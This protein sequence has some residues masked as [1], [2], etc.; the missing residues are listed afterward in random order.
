VSLR[1]GQI[2]APVADAPI[3]KDEFPSRAGASIY[4][5]AKPGLTAEWLQ[6]RIEKISQRCVGSMPN[7]ALDVANLRV[8]MDSGA[9]FAVRMISRDTAEAAEILRRA[10][11]LV[12]ACRAR[13]NVPGA[14]P[15]LF[16]ARDLD[17]QWLV[18]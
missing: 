13:A 2:S 11:S 14:L 17:C 10:R 12:E 9:G 1:R 5:A 15:G 18:G 7:C 4:V 3:C 6:L 16:P 8:K